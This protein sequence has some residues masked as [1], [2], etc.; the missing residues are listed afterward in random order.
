[1]QTL[2]AATTACAKPAE[3]KESS[4]TA[5]AAINANRKTKEAEALKNAPAIRRKTMDKIR[6]VYK[7]Q[8]DEFVEINFEELKQFD[9][10]RLVDDGE[11]PF[12]A[13]EKVYFALSN[14]YFGKG[15]VRTI[16]ADVVQ[17]TLKEEKNEA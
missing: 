17:L 13:G 16:D 3:T 4:T 12:E 7:K 5:E 8:G 1:M 10:F 15:G 6:H 2:F 9:Q 11:D 14:P